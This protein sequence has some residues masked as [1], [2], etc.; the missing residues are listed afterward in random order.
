MI[1]TVSADGKLDL[2]ARKVRC[3]LG[4]GGVIAGGEKREGDGM[5][6]AGRWPLRRVLFRADRVSPPATRLAARALRPNDAWCDAPDDDNYNRLVEWP[7]PASIERLWR[8][9]GLYDLLVVIGHN[10]A[11]VKPGAGSAIFLHVAAADYAAT[12]GCV[13]VARDDLIALLAVA[14]PGDALS[15]LAPQTP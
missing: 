12:Q 14:G 8:D 15:I 2:G 7:Y 1:F 10:D 6:P 5:T 13:A 11:P 4:P 3:A 9:D